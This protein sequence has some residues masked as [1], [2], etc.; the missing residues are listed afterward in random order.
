M[1]IENKIELI[2]ENYQNNFVKVKSIKNITDEYYEL[3]LNNNQL[4]PNDIFSLKEF[5]NFKLIK[6]LGN[7][8]DVHLFKLKKED[9]IE[10][11]NNQYYNK[12]IVI[13][14]SIKE[15][16][17]NLTTTYFNEEPLF[18]K[19][20]T[21]IKNFKEENFKIKDELDN[22]IKFKYLDF[23]NFQ[24]IYF[25]PK[26]N[27]KYYYEFN[28][29]KK[30]I[31]Y[32]SSINSI[33]KTISP[34]N[35]NNLYIKWFYIKSNRE[36]TIKVLFNYENYNEV[37]EIK[38]LTKELK[39]RNENCILLNKKVKS[40]KILS[41]NENDIYFKL[42]Y[43]NNIFEDKN[44]LY[45]L[46]D[47]NNYF[48]FKANLIEEYN[49]DIS[50]LENIDL[51]KKYIILNNKLIEDKEGYLSFR[52]VNKNDFFKIEDFWLKDKTKNIKFEQ[53]QFKPEEYYLNNFSS[54]NTLY[55]NGDK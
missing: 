19:F 29:T 41:H 37:K 46:K 44:K 11:N 16:I 36:E 7:K 34:Q 5:L 2:I 32:V 47:K 28:N 49:Y 20:M 42:N 4:K 17:N 27:K 35:I 8:K 21:E 22:E 9:L 15:E 48:L 10:F 30:I 39:H 53:I 12:Q 38:S 33:F 24:I 40:I 18:F 51:N 1:I 54:I 31:N 43:E 23:D 3:F 13:N 55:N 50:E 52:N 45:W 26:L 14:D 25:A 6:I